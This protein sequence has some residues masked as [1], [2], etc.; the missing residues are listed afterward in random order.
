VFSS[1]TLVP[2]VVTDPAPVEPLIYPYYLPLATKL[3]PE[4]A[5]HTNERGVTAQIDWIYVDEARTSVAF[6]VTGLDWPDGTQWDAMQ[7]RLSSTALPAS[8]YNGGGS[9]NVTAAEAGMITGEVDMFLADGQL[10]AEKT[11]RINVQVDL[12]LEGP[13]S[14]DHFRFQIQVPVLNGTRIEDIDQTAVANDVSMTL[15]TLVVHPSYVEAEFCFQM[16]SAVDWG[17]T[18]TRLTFGNREYTYSAG[19]LIQGPNGKDFQ[20]TDAERCSSIGFNVAYDENVSSLTLTVPKLLASVP[21][22]VDG[23]R[24]AIANERLSAYGIEIDYVNIDHGGTINVLQRPEGATDAQIYPLIW[25]AL[26]E[27]YEGPW[28]FIVEL[29]R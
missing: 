1:P 21:E 2:I 18:A 24:V 17:L 26:A 20:L 9:W 23:E 13:A 16:P 5:S 4:M 7:L 15:H 3:E 10:D 22:V 25:D 11:P 28:V 27:Q 29:P 8:A 14:T 12:P 6:T 19:G